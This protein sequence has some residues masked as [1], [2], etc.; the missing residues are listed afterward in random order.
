[1][2][3]SP[4]HFLFKFNTPFSSTSK[5]SRLRM[6]AVHELL[7]KTEAQVP[8]QSHPGELENFSIATKKPGRVLTYNELKSLK[9]INYCRVH[10]RR[11]EK[12]GEFPCRIR[13]GKGRIAW[14]EAKIDAWLQSKA[15]ARDLAS[16]KPRKG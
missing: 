6:A 16:G 8:A 4:K 14:S 15:D 9:G 5:M 3:T 7:G 11:L 2:K 12:A 10:I 13:L 1:M